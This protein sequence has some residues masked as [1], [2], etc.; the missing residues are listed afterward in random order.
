MN[1]Y[2]IIN[3][4]N[5]NVIDFVDKVNSQLLKKL[6]G[7]FEMNITENDHFKMENRN[8]FD[9]EELSPPLSAKIQSQLS[10]NASILSSPAQNLINRQPP[11][12]SDLILEENEE[13]DEDDCSKVLDEEGEVYFLININFKKIITSF[14]I[15]FRFSRKI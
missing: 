10:Q 15:N 3:G 1:K 14:K 7:S 11:K 4:S 6:N 12:I 5:D 13:T 8:D 9:E 2:S